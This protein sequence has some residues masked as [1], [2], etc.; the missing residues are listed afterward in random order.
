MS[1]TRRDALKLAAIAACA[2]VFQGLSRGKDM[3]LTDAK[4][5]FDHILVGSANLEAAVDWF[6][7][8]TGVRPVVGGRHPG[9]GTRNA[10]VSLGKP[11]YLELLAP[12]PEQP[13]VDNGRVRVF[14]SLA[15]PAPYTWAARTADIEVTRR[16]AE[17]AGLEFEG[18]TPGSR[19]RPDGR[20][21][22]WSALALADDLHGLLPFFIQWGPNTMHPSE[23]SPQGCTLH[24]LQLIAPDPERLESSLRVFNIKADVQKGPRARLAINLKTPQGEVQF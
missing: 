23:D 16:A 5:A 15:T 7:K 21:L 17:K 6:E 13:N 1:C 12:D 2:G 18:P 19:K 4:D 8:K 14:R 24:S 20:T 9:R 11:H 22:E 3:P 10:L